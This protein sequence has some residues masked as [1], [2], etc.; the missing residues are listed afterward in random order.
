MNPHYAMT[1]M[2]TE[3]ILRNVSGKYI[4]AAFNAINTV[5]RNLVISRYYFRAFNY[6]HNRVYG[7]RGKHRNGQYVPSTLKGRF[8]QVQISRAIRELEQVVPENGWNQRDLIIHLK[9]R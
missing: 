1:E 9:R 7:K 8:S 5:S 4:K 2:N 3:E 6:G